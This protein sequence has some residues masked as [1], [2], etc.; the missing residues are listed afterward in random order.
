MKRILAG[1]LALVLAANGLVMLIAGA[2]WYGAVPGVTQTGPF[3]PHFVQDIGAAYIV[4]GVVMVLLALRGEAW[5]LAAFTWAGFLA[6]HAAIHL[7]DALGG[8]HMG[9][10]LI[11]DAAGVYLLPILS[12]WAA[13]PAKRSA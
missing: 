12:L 13:W 1:L 7:K 10:D 9:A 6:F 3:N 8:H 2:W 11:R 4:A 5:R